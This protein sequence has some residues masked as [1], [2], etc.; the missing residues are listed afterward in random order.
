M[1]VYFATA[2]RYTKIGFSDDP[3]ARSTTVTRNGTRPDDLDFLA[4][5]QLI[6]WIPGDQRAER[7][8]H[9]RFADSRVAGEWFI[10]DE[11]VVRDLIWSDPR[12]VDIQR[13]SA[14]AVFVMAGNA[15]LTRADVA[16]AGV[17]VEAVPVDAAFASVDR[18]LSRR[19]AS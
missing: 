16:A 13:M 9:S 8:M 12:G 17:H 6:G 2:G 3:I 11:S 5:T 14:V 18:A 15:E 10:V 4:E 19:E 1:S 7:L